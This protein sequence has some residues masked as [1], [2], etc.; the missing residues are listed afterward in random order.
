MV[1]EETSNILTKCFECD[2]RDGFY[3]LS[4]LLGLGRCR[5]TTECG[6]Q[7]HLGTIDHKTVEIFTT[8]CCEG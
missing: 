5:V 3:A 6:I 8:A 4:L 1:D 7:D 2:E